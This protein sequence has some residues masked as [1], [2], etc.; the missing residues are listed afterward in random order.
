MEHKVSL[1]GKR[2]AV[3]G[4]A[5]SGLAAIKLLCQ[6][7]A[8]V[9]GSEV[10]P[11]D[12]LGRRVKELIA[13]GV[14]IEFGGHTERVLEETDLIVV[15]PGVPLDLPVLRQAWAR[16]IP[17][18][19][20]LELAY[21][22]CP[23]PIIAVTGSN[24]KT[25]VTT[26]LG[27]IFKED[28][29]EVMVAGNIGFP[30]SEAVGEVSPN[31]IVVAEVSSFQLEGIIHFRPQVSVILNITPD[32]LDRHPNFEQYALAKVRIMENQ[33]EGDYVVLNADDRVIGEVVKGV[34]AKVYHFGRDKGV[35]QGA[36]IGDGE[37]MVNVFGKVE[38]ICKV[39]ELG[40]RGPHNLSNTLAAVCV[41]R[42]WGVGVEGIRKT[43][44]RFSGIEHRLEF[45]REIQGVKFINDSKA[46]NVDAVRWALQS[47]SEP[48]VLIAG[49]REKDTDF[50]PLRPLVAQRV[51]ALVLIGEASD[52]I[53]QAM[54]GAV[55]TLRAETLEEAV[56]RAF[57]LAQEGDCVLLSPACASFDMF[58]D[59]EDRGQRFKEEVGRLAKSLH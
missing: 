24:G 55:E 48:I 19:S 22:F 15:S 37:I 13:S 28:G 31:G 11:L 6:A 58:R 38:R 35:D 59:F 54:D 18:V 39:D 41:A 57:S 1:S 44:R 27:E 46:T 42:I 25:T 23:A 34:K 36:F 45:V 21:W 50:T 14:E 29:R 52:K 9:F 17:V 20:E 2:V 53:A 32:H 51:K 10:R 33:D 16:A 56:G 43:L 8:R 7:G 47:F 3:L 30:L 49:G 4:L 5:R 40:L 12:Q 26:L